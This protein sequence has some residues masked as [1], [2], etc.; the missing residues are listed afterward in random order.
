MGIEKGFVLKAVEW[1]MELIRIRYSVIGAGVAG[2]PSYVAL[3]SSLWLLP[4]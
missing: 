2:A 4:A 1:W 3:R